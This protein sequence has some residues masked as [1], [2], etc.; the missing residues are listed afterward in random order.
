M[1]N[2]IRNFFS[3]KKETEKDHLKN[4]TIVKLTVLQRNARSKTSEDKFYQIFKQFIQQYYNMH[5]EFTYQELEQH[6]KY[7]KMK[8]ENRTRLITLIEEIIEF[9]FSQPN[10]KPSELREIMQK[11]KETI[12]II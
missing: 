2:K 3:E 8:H 7:K 5:F 11:T 12:K 6:L 4:K 1:L 10:K 9:R